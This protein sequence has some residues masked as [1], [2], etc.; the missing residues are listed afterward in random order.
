MALLPQGAAAWQQPPLPQDKRRASILWPRTHP[1][2]GR[3][4]NGPSSVSQ[5]NPPGGPAP[6]GMCGRTVHTPG[7]TDQGPAEALPAW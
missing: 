7:R 4:A 5:D 2:P 6:A 1:T 3:P